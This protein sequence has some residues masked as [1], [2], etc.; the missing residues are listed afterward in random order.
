L[1]TSA[2]DAGVAPGRCTTPDLS[3]FCRTEFIMGYE[4]EWWGMKLKVRIDSPL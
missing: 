3:N 4:I 1:V 2:V